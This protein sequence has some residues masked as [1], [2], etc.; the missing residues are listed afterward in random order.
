MFN[1]ISNHIFVYINYLD[2]FYSDTKWCAQRFIKF[3]D[4][5]LKLKVQC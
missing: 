3:T 4:K 5:N 1:L 2:T